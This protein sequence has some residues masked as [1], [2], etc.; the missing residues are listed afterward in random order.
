MWYF[1]PNCTTDGVSQ[2]SNPHCAAVRT[3]VGG[4]SC[5]ATPSVDVRRKGT[6]GG[7]NISLVLLVANITYCEPTLMTLG[8]FQRP[9]FN[10]SPAR[11]TG[12]LPTECHPDR[13]GSNES[14]SC[15]RAP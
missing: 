11:S 12:P 1:P 7:L 9:C 5:Q 15:R 2:L 10:W 4:S 6:I 3:G 13:S 8:S 14:A